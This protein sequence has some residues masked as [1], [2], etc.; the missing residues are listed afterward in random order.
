M[1]TLVEFPHELIDHIAAH[2]LPDSIEAFAI[3]CK[4]I[5]GK[6]NYAIEKHND[7]RKK[8]K[9]WS[10]QGTRRDDALYFLHAIAKDP[11]AAKYVE[12]LSFWDLRRFRD[13]KN[14]RETLGADWKVWRN[15][16]AMQ[17]IMSMVEDKLGA[18]LEA[19]SID[20][21]F[22][23]HRIRHEANPWDYPTQCL[24]DLDTPSVAPVERQI[25]G[26]ITAFTVLCLLPNLRQLTLHPDFPGS[27]SD[28]VAGLLFPIRQL[29]RYRPADG[30]YPLA[31]R[32]LE[33]LETLLP[34]ERD[35]A[36][37]FV[38]LEHIRPFLELPNL[39]N[40]FST[41]SIYEPRNTDYL[42]EGHFLDYAPGWID[43]PRG[44]QPQWSSLSLR[45]ME[46]YGSNLNHHGVSVLLQSCDQLEVFKYI[47][48]LEPHTYY[49]GFTYEGCNANLLV[50]H[51]GQGAGK[52]LKELYLR[53]A[54]Q[55]N[56]RHDHITASSLL[57]LEVLENLEI[58]VKLLACEELEHDSLAIMLPSSIKYLTMHIGNGDNLSCFQHLTTGLAA[59]RQEKLHNIKK[60]L[61]KDHGYSY[62]QDQHA[63][64]K[65]IVENEGVLWVDDQS[66]PL[67]DD[68]EGWPR[69]YHSKF[70]HSI[71]NVEFSDDEDDE[72]EQSKSSY[73]RHDPVYR[74]SHSPY[75]PASPFY[76]PLIH[77][78]SPR[79]PRSP[80]FDDF[81][82]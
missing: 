2:L 25:F 53:I 78:T 39:K 54:F 1:T 42:E 37:E 36:T 21:D 79:S 32:P 75:S 30:T 43:T 70:V 13:I 49:H 34:Y 64:T 51:L 73:Q 10:N 17:E 26:L 7:Y 5:Y 57:Q 12:T 81:T 55:S 77:S 22:W 58:D 71:E 18:Y 3:S 4:A 56:T 35:H 19:L 45:R 72:N 59:S 48:M 23:Y 29:F 80:T 8:Y 74:P 11:L 6:C 16:Q 52:S 44:F 61:V 20:T 66:N 60:I 69:E 82:P 62:E 65:K 47:C 28:T 33:K 46:L 40:V 67:T 9:T 41:S 14:A 76:S 68:L 24:A 27:R 38:S 15:A 31:Y 50:K 63:A